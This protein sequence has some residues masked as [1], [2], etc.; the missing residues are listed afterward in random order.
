MGVET[1]DCPASF[2]VELVSWYLKHCCFTSES[3]YLLPL[4]GGCL[5]VRV[6]LYSKVASD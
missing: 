1:V 5:P 3:V 6:S 4:A 2:L